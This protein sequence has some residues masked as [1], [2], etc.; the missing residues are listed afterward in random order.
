VPNSEGPVDYE[1]EY[2]NRA[3]VPEHPEIMAGWAR[4]AAAYRAAN[5]PLQI[6]YGARPRETLD[7]FGRQDRPVVLFIHGGYWQALDGSSFSHMARGL[8]VHGIAVAVATYDLCPGVSVD[9]ILGQMRD[10]TRLLHGK[11]GRSIIAVGHSAGGHLAAC[12]LATDWRALDPG[13]P[14]QL[15]HAACCLS[16]LFDLRPLLHTQ[17][18]RALKLDATEAARL[19]PLLWTPPAGA[20]LHAAVGEFESAEYHRQSREI[21]E[22]WSAGGAEASWEAVSGANHFTI[23]A[24]LADPDSRMVHEIANLATM[25][26]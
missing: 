3:R 22:R 15:V 12:L 26:R 19:S 4:D 20:R 9:T 13:L 14:A 17:L 11:T 6:A 5:P 7:L 21:A 8:N 2:N 24:P 18:N 23:I 1:R 16:G 25:A 10:A